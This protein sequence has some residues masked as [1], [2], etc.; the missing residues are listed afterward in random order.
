MSTRQTPT[1]KARAIFVK[2]GWSKTK[3]PCF[4]TVLTYGNHT[5]D[6]AISCDAAYYVSVIP[7][8]LLNRKRVPNGVGGRAFRFTSLRNLAKFATAYTDHCM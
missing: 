6:V 5:L 1:E 7:T 8:K 4:G 2:K 3:S